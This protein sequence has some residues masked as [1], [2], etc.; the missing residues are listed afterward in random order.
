MHNTRIC[1]ASGIFL[2]SDLDSLYVECGAPP[3][4]LLRNCFCAKM[5]QNRHQCHVTRLSVK[6]FTR[7]TAGGRLSRQD[8]AP[9]IIILRHLVDG[10][11]SRSLIPSKFWRIHPRS[12]ACPICDYLLV[13][14]MK[15]KISG[16]TY[17][18]YFQ[19]FSPSIRNTQQFRRVL[20]LKV[21]PDM[22]LCSVHFSYRLQKC[23][24]QCLCGQLSV[25]LP[26]LSGPSFWG[27]FLRQV[28]K[29]I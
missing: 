5:W 15:G 8:R 12:I 13:F 25:S 4:V 10:L 6:S 3:F 9:M 26:P 22:S 16:L 18:R 19:N 23:R 24:W 7:H 20:F 29:G 28:V 27:N 21:D 11:E 1:I 2:L 17:H 14:H